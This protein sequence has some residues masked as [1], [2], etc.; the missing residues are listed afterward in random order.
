MA[1]EHA[2]GVWCG[3]G[4][5][6]LTRMERAA[7]AKKRQY[8]VAMKRT[9]V[10]ICITEATSEAEARKQFDGGDYEV[11]HESECTDWE[12]AGKIKCDE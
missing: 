8:S 7:M 9:V 1:D 12:V 11:S 4:N 6:G 2:D 10:D 3:I 5:S